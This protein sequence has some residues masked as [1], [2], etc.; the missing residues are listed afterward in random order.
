MAPHVGDM[1]SEPRRLLLTSIQ[2]LG[3]TGGQTAADVFYL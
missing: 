1:T 2:G 3:Q